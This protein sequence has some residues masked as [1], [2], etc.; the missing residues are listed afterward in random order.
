M[1]EF[2]DKEKLSRFTSLSNNKLDL[3]KSKKS[4]IFSENVLRRPFRRIILQDLN[5]GDENVEV[6]VLFDTG[7]NMSLKETLD[8]GI[9]KKIENSRWC[10]FFLYD[11]SYS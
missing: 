10:F 8:K 5:T 11:E 7:S 4:Q 3:G 2:G 9:V 1:P 6:N